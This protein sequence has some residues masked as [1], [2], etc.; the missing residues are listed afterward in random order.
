MDAIVYDDHADSRS[1]D[2]DPAN[3]K[4]G[5][6]AQARDRVPLLPPT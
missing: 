4:S 3:D 6:F 2:M 5:D 1:S